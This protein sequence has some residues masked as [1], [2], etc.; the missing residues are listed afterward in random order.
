MRSKEFAHLA[1]TSCARILPPFWMMVVLFLLPN[2][3]LLTM[4]T[5]IFFKSLILLVQCK[6]ATCVFKKKDQIRW[7]TRIGYKSSKDSK[8]AKNNSSL[9][10]M[11]RYRSKA[12]FII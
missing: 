10:P 11:E 8:E 12:S 2:L 1:S 9:T 6:L 7:R 5:H 3:T 4:E